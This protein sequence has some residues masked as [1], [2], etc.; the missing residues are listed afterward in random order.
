MRARRRGAAEAGI[1][2]RDG[3][4]AE[5]GETRGRNRRPTG[6]RWQSNR[7]A[8]GPWPRGYRAVSHGGGASVPCAPLR[9]L[10]VARLTFGRPGRARRS[11]AARAVGVLQGTEGCAPVQL[12]AR[13]SLMAMPGDVGTVRVSGGPAAPD[14]LGAMGG[15]SRPCRGLPRPRAFERPARRPRTAPPGA[16]PPRHPAPGRRAF[17]RA[18]LVRRPRLARVDSGRPT[19]RPT[20]WVRRAWWTCS[21]LLWGCWRLWRLPRSSFE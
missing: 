3:C 10:G 20:R 12:R 15:A 13:I 16:C 5:H 21:A 6:A 2:L 11:Q 9:S 14:G 17:R 4:G 1:E 19:G 18:P 8:V 7:D